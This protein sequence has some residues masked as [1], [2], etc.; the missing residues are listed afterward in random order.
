MA[1]IKVVYE[2]VTEVA[3]LLNK[4]TNDTV[5]ALS[6]VQDTVNDLL[7]D[8][9]G[10]WLTQSSPVMQEKYSA[11]NTAVNEAVLSIPSWANQFNNIVA[12]LQSL[13]ES[14]AEQ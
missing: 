5:P 11:F 3:A 14:L 6:D 2:D 4:V 8:G 13:D 1:D 10:L 7:E 9:G 12:Q